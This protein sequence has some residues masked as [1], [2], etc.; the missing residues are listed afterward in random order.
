[1]KFNDNTRPL[2]QSFIQNYA[3]STPGV[4]VKDA[5]WTIIARAMDLPEFAAFLPEGAEIDPILPET[6]PAASSLSMEDEGILAAVHDFRAGKA[7]QETVLVL[8]GISLTPTGKVKKVKEPKAPKE[9]KAAKAPKEPKDPN[10][11]GKYDMLKR[12]HPSTLTFADGT[13]MVVTT[14]EKT[15][16]MLVERALADGKPV[17][18][19]WTRSDEAPNYVRAPG[20]ALYVE[21]FNFVPWN[22]RRINIISKM[23]G[24][25]TVAYG[26]KGDTTAS[27][28]DFGG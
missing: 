1:M 18:E 27:K 19:K 23:Y 17:P 21:S 7:T 26:P 22:A 6:S 24:G 28:I 9:P 12:T 14:W 3:A 20:G 8:L 10:A 2:V 11:A 4:P 25:A 13:E 15:Y 16:H 5:A